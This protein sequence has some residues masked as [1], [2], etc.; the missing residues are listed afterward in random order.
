MA[1]NQT[2]QNLGNFS[3]ATGA[4][5]SQLRQG[6]DVLKEHSSWLGRFVG[7]LGTAISTLN[8]YTIELEDSA[9]VLQRTTTLIGNNKNDFVKY[10]TEIINQGNLFSQITGKTLQESQTVIAGVMSALKTF[11]IEPSIKLTRHQ[12]TQ[13]QD[14][15]REM[16]ESPVGSEAQKKYEKL[17]QGFDPAQKNMIDM[18][19]AV[20]LLT[21]KAGMGS[22][23]IAKFTEKMAGVL[24][25]GL[26]KI[27]EVASIITEAN[28]FG[29]TQHE[30]MAQFTEQQK[31]LQSIEK[32]EDRIQAMRNIAQAAADQKRAGTD[33]LDAAKKLK[34]EEGLS[35]LEQQVMQSA[36]TGRSLENIQKVQALAEMNDP[37][38]QRE[39]AR[40]QLETSGAAAGVDP[41][42]L[43]EAKARIATGQGT[44]ADFQ[45]YD[46]AKTIG[47]ERERTFLGAAAMGSEGMT[48]RQALLDRGGRAPVQIRA[49]TAEDRAREAAGL[50]GMLTV[51]EGARAAISRKQGELFPDVEFL[52]RISENQRKATIGYA[53]AREGTDIWKGVANEQLETF[54][55]VMG[56]GLGGVLGANYF[57]TALGQASLADS[58]ATATLTSTLRTPSPALPAPSTR[59]ETPPTVP[60]GAEPDMGVQEIWTNIY[61]VLQDV[62]ERLSSRRIRSEDH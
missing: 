14:A 28:K 51:E 36:M 29:L 26:D 10:N 53:V 41:R 21:V 35:R 32:P 57:G 11:D 23:E 52:R 4:V 8:K 3:L 43:G 60:T 50:S 24:D 61:N 1:A 42:R 39:M 2:V 33:F 46:Y 55:K 12:L 48:A 25:I 17:I 31:L 27:P 47:A 58:V 9:R 56:L 18:G 6:T 13:L 16:A 22:D 19:N 49:R 7:G 5:S 54:G 15:A 62:A 37:K 30:L 45:M 44:A 20:S 34:G 59:G 38:A 40:I